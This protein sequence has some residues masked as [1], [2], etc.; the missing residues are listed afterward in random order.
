MADTINLLIIECS[1]DRLRFLARELSRA[2]DVKLVGSFET[3]DKALEQGLAAER[4]DV[5]LI[6]VDPPEVTEIPFWAFLRSLLWNRVRV[7]AITSTDS[8]RVLETMLAVG[9]LGLH[10]PGAQPRVLLRAIR[11]ASDN[12]TD[13][14][15]LLGELARRSLMGVAGQSAIRVGALEVHLHRHLVRLGDN[16]L[17]LTPLEFSLLS[18]LARNR[19]RPVGTDEL[20]GAVWQ[21]SAQVGGTPDQVKGCVKRIRAKI[22]RLAP[23]GSYLVSVRGWGYQLRDPA[24]GDRWS[25]GQNQKPTHL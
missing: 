6:D 4:V 16:A 22:R 19:N 3:L 21:V 20:L 23:S 25:G 13:F 7:V 5:L 14:D 11:A 1:T 24:A 17:K 12:A 2:A 18:Y 15:V 10:P 9:V 8:V